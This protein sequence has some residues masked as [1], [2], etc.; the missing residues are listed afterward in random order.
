MKSGDAEDNDMK[1]DFDLATPVV[2]LVVKTKN[3]GD[4]LEPFFAAIRK[5]E[6]SAP[7]ELIIVDGSTDDTP[8]RL[9]E[10][11]ASFPNRISVIGETRPGPGLACDIGWRATTAPIIAFTDDDCYPDPDYLTQVQVVIADPDL[12]FVGGRILLYDPTDAPVTINELNTEVDFKAGSFV[13]PGFIQGA[14]MA[15]RRQALQDIEGFDQDLVVGGEDIDVVLRVLAAG[16]NGKYDPRPLVY[17]HHRRKPGSHLEKLI[18]GYAVQRG[19]CYMKCILFMPQ[20]WQCALN[21]LRCM[22]RQPIG[23]SIRELYS[24]MSYVLHLVGKKP[25]ISY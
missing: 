18:K 13:C 24:A 10:F 21:W 9:A 22:R 5:I 17:H 2:A 6:F 14:N 1:N 4:R 3:R 8:T 12:G 25:N 16:W 23:I 7:W 15:F 19:I 11:A 20:R